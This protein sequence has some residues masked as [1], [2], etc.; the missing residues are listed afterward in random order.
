MKRHCRLYLR[1]L[2]LKSQAHRDQKMSPMTGHFLCLPLAVSGFLCLHLSSCFTLSSSNCLFVPPVFP[3]LPLC[4]CLPFSSSG[5]L[6]L[7]LASPIFTYLPVF[8]CLPLTASCR[9]LFV[10]PLSSAVFPSLPF[11]FSGCLCLPL[12]YSVFF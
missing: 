10:P 12:S 2:P 1:L 9:F 4:S 6:C 8:P 11:P 3:C 5:C 7:P